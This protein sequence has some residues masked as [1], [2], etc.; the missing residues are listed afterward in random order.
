MKISKY[1]FLVLVTILVT[2]ST[3][4]QTFVNAFKEFDNQ[5]NDGEGYSNFNNL[6]SD[7]AWGES[8]ILMSYMAMFRATGDTRFLR[9][10]ITH[11]KNIINQRD[12]NQGRVDYRGVSAATWI[13]INQI[14]EPYAWVVHS[15]MITYPMADFVNLV[16][17]TD[18][19]KNKMSAEGKR[20]LEEAEWLQKEIELTILAHED[21]WD[22]ESDV[23]RFRQTELFGRPNHVLPHN[24][25]ATM[26]RTLLMMS[27][28]TGNR[29]YWQ[30]VTSLAFRFKA[31]LQYVPSDD[32]Y[33]WEYDRFTPVEDLSHGALEVDF[34]YLCFQHGIVFDAIDMKRFA[35]TFIRNIYLDPLKFADRVDGSGGINSYLFD[36]GMWLPI[37]AFDSNIY[38]AVADVFID[39]SLDLR[40]PETT[41]YILYGI[42][43][44][45]LFQSDLN[46][47]ATFRAPGADSKWAGIAGG[48]FDNDEEEELVAVR[49]SD[50]Q[51][52]LYE[53][54]KDGIIEVARTT[55][56]GADSEWAGIAA[57]DFDGDGIDEIVAVRNSDSQIH[58]FELQGGQ[59]MGITSTDNIDENSQ[60]VGI[61]AGDFDNDGTDEIVAVRNFDSQIHMFELEGGQIKEVIST[62]YIGHDSQWVGIAAGDFDNDK[63]DE[64]VAVRNSDAQ[65]HMFELEP[66]NKKIKGVVRTTFF[67]EDS[68]WTAIAA[69]NFDEDEADEIVGSRGVDGDLFFLNYKTSANAED[70]MISDFDREFFPIEFDI[71]ELGAGKLGDGNENK[72]AIFIVRDSDS[73]FLLYSTSFETN[74]IIVSAKEDISCRR[75]NLVPNYYPNPAVHTLT[76][77]LNGTSRDACRFQVYDNLGR[78]LSSLT[79]ATLPGQDNKVLLNIESLPNG[80]YYL[81]VSSTEG[82]S[83]AIKFMKSER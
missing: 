12:D 63:V 52:Y 69:G 46:P 6:N 60:W 48:N 78:R 4:A 19:L 2:H 64:I 38:H 79:A 45:A 8:Y 62:D 81:M 1:I 15:G 77:E 44:C 36:T 31:A 25:Y 37:S 72:D 49:N 22:T 23:Y 29:D 34:A 42:A 21:Q 26:G 10:L 82:Y 14:P 53:L 24:Q 43:N 50:S 56:I 11:S 65:I 41:G 9:K 30:K 28:A 76:V 47:I 3:D 35:N 80:I 57:G 40:T 55:Y 59:I 20:F 16:M 66:G 67:G 75:Q 54:S 51:I 70:T 58:M 74:D 27:L 68:E 39:K 73:N 13:D 33:V 32:S 71:T 61:A 5:L 17:R 83:T 7:L 18:T